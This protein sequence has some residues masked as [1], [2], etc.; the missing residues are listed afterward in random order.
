MHNDMKRLIVF[1][2]FI[3]VAFGLF[4]QDKVISIGGTTGVTNATGSVSKTATGRKIAAYNY[5]YQVDI[6]APIFYTYS[7]NL[8]DL[9]GVPAGNTATAVLS[10]SLDN[11]KYKTITSVSYHGVG[12]DTAI[13]GGITSSPTSY[14]Y[15]KWTITPSDTI[16][17][18]HIL[19]NI[20]P[21]VK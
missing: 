4:A 6:N 14:K 9:G 7:V 19:M 15:Y 16:W 11:V 18:E 5:V 13:I 3:F 8:K 20:Q 17:V 10:G 21:S 2:S 12:T 1:L